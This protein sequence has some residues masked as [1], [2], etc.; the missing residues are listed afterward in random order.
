MKASKLIK[1]LEKA[2]EENSGDMDVWLY[3]Q[4]QDYPKQSLRL[5]RYGME[6][7]EVA[8]LIQGT[9]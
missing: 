1:E 6:E 3:V 7:D 4:N 5:A 2:I 9:K 8:I